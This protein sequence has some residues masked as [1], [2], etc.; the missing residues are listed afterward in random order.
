MNWQCWKN[1]SK[2]IWT[3]NGFVIPPVLQKPRYC[4]YPKKNGGL[5]FCVDYRKLNKITVKSRYFFPLINE[6][7]DRFN[8][9]KIFIKLDLKNAYYR[10]RNRENDKWKTAFRT[11]YGHFEYTVI[12]FGLI[13]IPAIFRFYINNFFVGL[14]NSTWFISIIFP[15]IRKRI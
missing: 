9:F 13:N 8:G 12:S 5:R 4:S 6:T 11:G 1:I 2:K 3:K 7:L 10:I 15:F 14:I